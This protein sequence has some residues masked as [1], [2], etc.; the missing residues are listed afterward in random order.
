M[1]GHIVL[2]L[3]RYLENSTSM[4]IITHRNKNSMDKKIWA[5]EPTVAYA[6]QFQQIY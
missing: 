1:P 2:K 6:C 3:S 4:T 5:S